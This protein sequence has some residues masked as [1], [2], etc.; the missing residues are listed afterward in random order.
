MYYVLTLIR[1]IH[2]FKIVFGVHFKTYLYVFFGSYLLQG[3][4]K[5]NLSCKYIYLELIKSILYYCA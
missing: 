4:I 5:R 1:A 3:Q 2:V